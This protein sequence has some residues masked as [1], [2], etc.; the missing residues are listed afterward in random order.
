MFEN[1]L[2]H[3]IDIFRINTPSFKWKFVRKS[4]IETSTWEKFNQSVNH[5]FLGFA[6]L[7]LNV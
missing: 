4:R 1:M 3:V 6:I 5:A 7:Q 2:R